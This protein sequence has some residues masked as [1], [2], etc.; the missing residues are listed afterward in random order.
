MIEMV[1]LEYLPD[2]L[3][4]PVYM[5]IPADR[6][7]KFVVLKR[8]GSAKENGLPSTV[9]ALNS[10]AQSLYEA[11]QLNEQVKAAMEESVDLNEVSACSLST[12]Y[13]FTDTKSKQYCYQA[14]FTMTHY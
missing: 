4:V 6:D 5:E 13:I 1:L 12:D 7:E 14:V 2:R 8:A 3:G 11:A 10:Y 9:L